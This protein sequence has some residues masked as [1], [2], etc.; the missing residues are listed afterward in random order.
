M[1]ILRTGLAA[2]LVIAAGAL[3]SAAHAQDLPLSAFFGRWVGG[4]VAEN[5]GSL[6]FEETARDLDVLIG[7]TDG[8]FQVIWSTV[9]RKGGDPANPD[10]E[11]KTTELTFRATDRANVF[12][13]VPENS[14]YS[15]SGLSW[16]RLEGD[17]LTTYTIRVLED[18]SYSMAS[19][20][21]TVG[22]GGMD[23]AFKS[24]RDGETVRT[25]KAKL[26]KHSE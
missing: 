7:P 3:E 16:A 1:R 21:R 12:A 17:T 25:V 10:I 14:P 22:V 24:I 26:V 20:A 13:A 5:P 9:L 2:L 18:G 19:Y 11:R 23:L 4:G 8:G 6:F 15:E